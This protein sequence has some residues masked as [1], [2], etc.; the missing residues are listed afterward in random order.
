MGLCPRKVS[1]WVWQFWKR[2]R[3]LVASSCHPGPVL[4]QPENLKVL[5]EEG[6]RPA[7]VPNIEEAD[8][9]QASR[10][11]VLFLSALCTVPN[12]SR[13][14]SK[15]LMLL[16]SSKTQQAADCSRIRG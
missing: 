14:M 2:K 8:Q 10:C 16:F 15:E 9:E 6:I 5:A 1:L 12:L 4:C 13:S 11:P 7:G 3:K